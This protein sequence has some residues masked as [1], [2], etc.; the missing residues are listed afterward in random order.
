MSLTKTLKQIVKRCIPHRLVEYRKQYNCLLYGLKSKL[1]TAKSKLIQ[2]RYD[3][4]DIKEVKSISIFFI[5]EYIMINGGVMMLFAFAKYSRIVNKEIFVAV[6]TCGEKTYAKNTLFPNEEKVYR[7]EQFVNNCKCLENL[8]LNIPEYM[9]SYFYE[10]LNDREIKFLKSI[11]NLQ[12]NIMNQNILLMPEPEKLKQLTILTNNITQTTG[13]EKYTTQEICDKWGYPLY[14]LL[15]NNGIDYSVFKKPFSQKKDIFYYSPDTHPRKEEILEHLRSIL[16]KF[17]FV[18]IRNLTYTSFL[19]FVSTCKFSITFGEGFDG[20]ITDIHGV[21]G[22]GFAVFNNEFFPSERFLNFANIFSS[23]DDLKFNIQ[24]RI[25][26]L[27][28]DPQKYEDCSKLLLDE[29]NKEYK[30]KITLNCLRDFYNHKPT[31]IPKNVINS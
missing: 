23:W 4:S 12:L 11:K 16:P 13:F 3:L 24:E 1:T 29:V 17:K 7:F 30:E 9:A 8:I 15:P 19:K 21:G 2:N 28:D 10:I 31:F 14:F 26:S 22:I 6:S 20:Y 27:L 18:E 5:P 25:K